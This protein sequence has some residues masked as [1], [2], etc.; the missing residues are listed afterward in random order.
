MSIVS[1]DH[2]GWC[3]RKKSMACVHNGRGCVS[4]LP[5]DML[6]PAANQ[7][8]GSKS[9]FWQQM[10]IKEKKNSKSYFRKT[11]FIFGNKKNSQKKSWRQITFCRK[12]RFQHIWQQITDT[13]SESTTT[14]QQRNAPNS[15]H[16]NIR[17]HQHPPQPYRHYTRVPHNYHNTAAT[18][19]CYPRQSLRSPL[20]YMIATT[21]VASRHNI[22]H[23]TATHHNIRHHQHSPQ[24]TTL[25]CYSPQHSI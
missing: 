14:P 3:S 7:A 9:S 5:P 19:H 23:H 1:R 6:K 11:V 24:H 20:I 4:D 25:H 13:P 2:V 22:R 15:I 21:T 16:H 10:K 8:F 12:R 17:Q 18:P